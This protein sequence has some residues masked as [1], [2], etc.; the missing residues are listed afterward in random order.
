MFRLKNIILTILV[1]LYFTVNIYCLKVLSVFEPPIEQFGVIGNEPNAWPYIY[2][3][4]YA[5]FFEMYYRL[6]KSFDSNAK[7]AMGSL[8]SEELMML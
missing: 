6:I 1:F 8:Y 5:K 2:P 3:C 7:I 4:D